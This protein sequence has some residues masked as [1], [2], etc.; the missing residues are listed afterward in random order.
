LAKTDTFRTLAD[1]PK[2]ILKNQAGETVCGFDSATITQLDAGK[3]QIDTEPRFV[4]GELTGEYGYRAAFVLYLECKEHRMRTS[5]RAAQI[6]AGFDPE[7][8]K[9]GVWQD[10]TWEEFIEAFPLSYGK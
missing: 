5:L 3:V 8:F 6:D 4:S 7:I 10:E 1:L 9:R 2:P